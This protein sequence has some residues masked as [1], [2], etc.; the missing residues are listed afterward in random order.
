MNSPVFLDSSCFIY[1]LENNPNYSDIT[2]QIFSN[3]SQSKLQAKTSLITVTEVL[4]KPYKENDQNYIKEYQQI[5]SEMQNLEILSPSFQT[6]INAAKI[7]ARYNL[8]LPDSY[9]LQMAIDSSCKT[10]LTNDVHLKKVR[11]IKIVVLKDL[12]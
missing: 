11:E 1:L 8:N 6:S 10:F 9:Q 12:I 7:R 5:F 2:Q 4:T 3:I